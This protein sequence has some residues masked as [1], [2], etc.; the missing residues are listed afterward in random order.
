MKLGAIKDLLPESLK[1]A[2]LTFCYAANLGWDAAATLA[3]LGETAS[4]YD[5]LDKMVEC[6]A[7]QAQ[8]GDHIL[9]MSNGG[10]GG[11]HEKL[12]KRLAA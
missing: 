10:F 2:D 12:L 6:I 9:V 3:P 8:R 4:A 5:D 1:L 11:I 7:Q